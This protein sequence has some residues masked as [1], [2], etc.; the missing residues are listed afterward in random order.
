VLIGLFVL[1]LFAQAANPPANQAASPPSSPPAKEAAHTAQAV[2]LLRQGLLDLQANH[3]EEARKG[4]EAASQLEP[5]NPFVWTSL[6]ETYWR[7]HNKDQA[8]SA[9]GQAAKLRGENA[10]VAHALAM[11]YSE[12][13]QFK[14]A[15]AFE[16]RYAASP[17]ADRQA[18]ARVAA[19]YLSAGDP[20]AALAAARQA[21]SLNPS[22][23]NSNLLGRAAVAAG[24]KDEGLPRLAEA[25][26]AEPDNEAFCFDYVQ[27]LLYAGDFS[28]ASEVLDQSLKLHPSSV[29]LT[30]ALGVTRYG[31][32]RF[33]E[34]GDA[35]LKTLALDP[36]VP[37]PYE[38]LGKML[39]QLNARLPEITAA[40]RAW[41]Q[42]NPSN[43]EASL[44]LAKALSAGGVDTAEIEKLLRSSIALNDAAWES[45]SE[46]GQLLV[47]RRQFAEAAAELNK[48]IQ[49]APDQPQPHYHLARV[50]DRLGEADKAKQE[51]DIHARLTANPIDTPGMK[52]VQR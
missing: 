42:R 32:R 2:Q 15:A 12:A 23:A 9:A 4:L 37:Q 20:A 41:H 26:R 47:K 51:R 43:A 34:A 25:C 17:S 33:D 27:A 3:L 48:A 35:F 39:E 29:Q 13:G 5:G 22:P 8:F 11:F 1:L 44:L 16:Q 40:Y 28:T 19:L 21:I 49:L 6:A 36:T 24:N 30:L 18:F 10:A 31:Q 45:H 14:Q 38:F 46:L 52:I 50:Y 7:L